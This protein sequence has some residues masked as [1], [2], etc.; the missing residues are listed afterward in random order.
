MAPLSNTVIGISYGSGLTGG[1]R[2]RSGTKPRSYHRG[3]GW[4]IAEVFSSW[5][6]LLAKWI[7]I[8]SSD[9]IRSTSIYSSISSRERE[10]ML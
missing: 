5:I 2:G 3:P 8:A 1:R 9:L 10:D 4:Y 7:G 6:F